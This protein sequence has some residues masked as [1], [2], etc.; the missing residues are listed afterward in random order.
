M[1][2]P[3]GRAALHF[4]SKLPLPTERQPVL[5]MNFDIR[6]RPAQVTISEDKAFLN[7]H[8]KAWGL[9]HNGVSAGLS[10]ALKAQEISASWIDY[11]KPEEFTDGHAG[12]LLGL[13]LNG[14]LKAMATWHAFNYLTSKHTMTSIGLLLG[15]SASFLGSEDPMIT[16]LLSVHVLALLPPGSNELNLSGVTQAAGVAGIG[17]LYY[18]T[19]NRKMSEVMLREIAGQDS[20][21]DHFRDESYRLS[22]GLS[23]GMINVGRGNELVT[24]QDLNCVQALVESLEG[25]RREKHDLDVKMAGAIV[26]LG[27]I[28]L[29]T[30]DRYVAGRLSV[31]A[32][33]Y[34]LRS[35]RPDLLLLRVLARGLVMWDEV[36]PT[37][38]YV[39][40]QLPQSLRDSADL[41]SVKSYRSSDLALFN[42]V[43][44]VCLSIGM[45]YAGTLDT[46]A[47]D[48]LLRYLDIFL[49]LSDIDDRGVDLK[50]CKIATKTCLSVLAYSTSMV[51][52]G[53][54][55]L[56][57]LRRLR[58]LH[59]RLD[60]DTWYGHCMAV[61]TSIGLLFASGGQVSLNTSNR[62]ICAFVAA[63]YPVVPNATDD[64][65]S[66]LQALRHLWVLG[67]EQRCLIPRDIHTKQVSLVPILITFRDS[68]E[69]LQ[70]LAPCLLPP[71]QTLDTITIQSSEHWPVMLDLR[72][73][74]EH[75][76]AL[77]ANQ[78]F[79]ITRRSNSEKP[80]SGFVSQFA[81]PSKPQKRN[82]EIASELNSIVSAIPEV[83]LQ[84]ILKALDSEEDW[85][86]QMTTAKCVVLNRTKR[87]NNVGTQDELRTLLA[88]WNCATKGQ[89]SHKFLPQHMIFQEEF[90]QKLLLD[91]WKG[92]TMNS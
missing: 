19:G 26:A 85:Q 92:K 10:I 35:I 56:Q 7:A 30:H 63:F 47:R 4:N 17:L 81:V 38:G 40:L 66:H 71:L 59:Y 15:L 61:E 91:L 3:L 1:A 46:L 55:D 64:N 48:F 70:R 41:S 68:K 86:C 33:E 23:L 84:S 25:T 34:G 78:T 80:H 36:S 2:I 83:D 39:K 58:R 11:N 52:A 49:K 28:Y 73:S 21:I 42:V 27:L 82:F 79:F 69:S 44:G 67:T 51:M 18:D 45:K 12:F 54:G 90:V 74:S 76:H 32:T 16:K 31:P 14:H 29:R 6:I 22:A 20:S 60:L 43:V 75:L 65:K 8:V 24:D 37:I 89:I 62:A 5:K 77:Q 87:R 53:S 9:F 72:E 88:W 50:A 57:V 13:G